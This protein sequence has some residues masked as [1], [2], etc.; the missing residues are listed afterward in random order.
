[1]ATPLPLSLA[2][3]RTT[4]DA[5]DI[6]GRLSVQYQKDSKQ[7]AVYGGFIWSQRPDATLITLLS[8]L[9]QTLANIDVTSAGAT[10]RRAGQPQRSAPDANTLV[11]EALGWPLPVSGLREW[12][13][14]FVR[15]AGGK[16]LSVSPNDD[17]VIDTDDGWQLRYRN[18]E[19]ATTD[20]AAHPKRIDLT[21]TT[22]EA[23]MVSIRIVVDSWQPTG[24]Q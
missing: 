17:S 18:W 5:I 13:Q 16:T 6:G 8:P 9:G 11:A 2:A 14:G 12:L 15:D 22:V 1:M 20:T 7:E 3:T 21:R 10:L 19:A 23:G 4:I 24:R